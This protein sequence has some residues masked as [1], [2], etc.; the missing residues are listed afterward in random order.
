MSKVAI[1]VLADTET[2]GDLGRV[3]N[4]LVATKEFKSGGDDVR[5]ILDGAATKWPGILSNPGHHA[6][7]LFEEVRDVIAGACGFCTKAF[8]ATESLQHAHVEPLDEYEGH[9]SIRNLVAGGYQ[10]ISF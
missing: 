5:L 3:F 9:P 10:I 6:H 8:E 4:A 2:H 7:R 1:L